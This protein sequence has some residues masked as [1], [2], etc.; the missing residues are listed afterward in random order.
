MPVYEEKTHIWM[1]FESGL[2]G[3]SQTERRNCWCGNKVRTTDVE[4][5]QT[6]HPE[7]TRR[8]QRRREAVVKVRPDVSSSL[9][10][11]FFLLLDVGDLQDGQQQLES[12][13]DVGST[14][15]RLRAE[16]ILLKQ[17]IFKCAHTSHCLHR[18]NRLYKWCIMRT[19]N[20]YD[21]V[22]FCEWVVD[23]EKG[24]RRNSSALSLL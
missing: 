11:G 2:R 10:W 14:V 15:G 1:S 13:L 21:S 12:I 17:Q 8:S 6:F 16:R 22:D 7:L 3:R 9:L 5:A 20:F 4:L 19:N 18:S 24:C 23:K